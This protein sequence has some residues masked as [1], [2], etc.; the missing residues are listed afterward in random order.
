M[1]NRDGATAI[2][3][4]EAARLRTA[5]RATTL[6]CEVSD[7]LLDDLAPR[8]HAI[9]APAGAVLIQQGDTGREMYLVDQGLLEVRVSGDG[10]ARRLGT[11]GP[12][13]VFGEMALLRAEP[14]MAAVSASQPSRVWV[15]PAEAVALVMRNAPAIGASLQ[16]IM[17]RRQ[18]ANAMRALQ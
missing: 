7:E 3:P 10:V 4:T 17:R 1:T 16:G 12:G 6:F 18:R 11:L 13:D 15:L 9:D 5:L 2:D 14:R 8:I